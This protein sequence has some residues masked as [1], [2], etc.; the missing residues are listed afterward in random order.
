MPRHFKNWLDAYLRHTASSEAP[1]HL[2]FWTGVSTLA[3]AL[4]RRVWRNEH[5]FQWTPNFYIILVGPAGVVTKSTTIGL[6]M[7]LLTKITTPTGSK[8]IHFGPESMSWQAL[9]MALQESAEVMLYEEE[10]EE[11]KMPMAPITCSISELG[12]FLRTQDSELTSFLT[13]MWD[14]QRDTFRHSTVASSKIEVENPWLNIIA[15]TTPSW[16]KNNFPENLIGDGLTS[17]IVFVYAE[18]K[19]H[20]VAY[21]SQR[22]VQRDYY[23][24]EEKL[25]ED[26]TI[27]A[28]LAGPYN[29]TDEAMRWGT[30]WYDK[31]N[32]SRPTHMASDRYGGYIARKQAHLHK[33][34]IVLAAAK[35][36]ALVIEKEDLLEAEQH[37]LQAEH[38]MIRVFESIGLVDEAKKVAELVAYVRA[39]G[40]IEANM[41]WRSCSNIM[42][43]KDFR[44]ALRM[45]CEA[46]LI[47]VETREGKRGLAAIEPTKH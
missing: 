46:G 17:R 36:D 26:L 30:D 32:S 28:N 41:L 34:A 33:V 5:V 35:R 7:R 38:S 1:E 40:W 23:Q 27:I 8:A 45:A 24:F 37:L 31:H 21:P 43:E 44:Q 39:Y 15:A 47:K 6:G 19:R 29:L 2:H 16:L 18:N 11:R 9:G 22:I 3:G 4:R 12:T 10:G 14:S 25:V 20:L 13:R 42:M